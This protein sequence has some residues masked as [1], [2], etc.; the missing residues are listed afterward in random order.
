MIAALEQKRAEERVA[1]A[2]LATEKVLHLSSA[3]L[4]ARL[5][6]E[7]AAIDAE[8]PQVVFKAIESGLAR[9]FNKPAQ[10][11]AVYRALL[12]IRQRQSQRYFDMGPEITEIARHFV[13]PQIDRMIDLLNAEVPRVAQRPMSGGLVVLEI[14]PWSNPLL[15]SQGFEA[16]VDS[17]FKRFLAAAQI[18]IDTQG[19]EALGASL[20]GPIRFAAAALQAVVRTAVSAIHNAALL[21]VY[22]RFGDVVSGYRWITT[23]RPEERIGNHYN[24]VYQLTANVLPPAHIGSRS[25]I[26]PLFYPEARVSERKAEVA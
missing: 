22:R 6:G 7:I 18:F 4:A 20:A 19:K 3:E 26:A 16:L 25:V 1:V 2:A 8:V 21:A 10:V 12:P 5:A 9:S 17:K 11:A 24:V 15:D 14:D 13:A 23:T